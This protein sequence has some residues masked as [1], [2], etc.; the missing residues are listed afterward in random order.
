MLVITRKSGQ[1]FKIGPD[2]EVRILGERY[3]QIKIG[4][5]APRETLILRSELQSRYAAPVDAKVG[6]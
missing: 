6:P 5:T 3:G 4:I 2:V 1:S